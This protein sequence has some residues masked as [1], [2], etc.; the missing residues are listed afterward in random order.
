ME[1]F[2]LIITIAI[3]V[4]TSYLAFFKHTTI[5]GGRRKIYVDSSVLI[6][7]RIIEIA[8]TGFIG[9]EM[10]ILKSVLRELQL[11][12]DG[13]D[14]EKRNRGRSGLETAAE[15]ERV[16]GVNTMIVNDIPELE[17]VQVDEQLLKYA[18]ENKGWVL[19]LDYNLLKVAEAENIATLNI[20][21]LSLAVRNEFATGDK[22]EIKIIE[23]GSNKGQGV[24]YLADGTM[25][26]VDK[27]SDKIGQEIM[28]ELVK[29]HET[30]AG[31]MFF[32]RLAA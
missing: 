28:V 3:L 6:D 18:K 4:E 16:V 31:K 24:G 20:N 17:R 19:T 25:V 26:V 23:K 8:K 32:A 12:A 27:A 5:G 14:S 10:I 7:G 1:L 15:L 22:V 30:S 11:L 13:K 2:I 9:G 21:D 29:F